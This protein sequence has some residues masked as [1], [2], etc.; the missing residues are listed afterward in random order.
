MKEGE[1]SKISKTIIKENEE[2]KSKNVELS[3]KL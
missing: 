3:E 1:R 2:L